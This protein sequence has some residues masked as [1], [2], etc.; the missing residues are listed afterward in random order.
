MSTHNAHL[1]PIEVNWT[2]NLRTIWSGFG[3]LLH[4]KF[5]ILIP[6]NITII[7]TFHKAKVQVHFL[8][9]GAVTL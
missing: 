9:T 5:G 8:H 2:E 1:F 6:A 4:V 7:S 3:S